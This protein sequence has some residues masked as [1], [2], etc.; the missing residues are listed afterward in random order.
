[1]TEP[2][3][4]EAFPDDG[5]AAAASGTIRPKRPS[6]NFGRYAAAI[7]AV[8]V[9]VAIAFLVRRLAGPESVDLAFLVFVIGVAIRYG[10]G[11]SFIASILS[12]LALN[13]FFVVPV[14]SFEVA[15]PTNLATLFFF[16]VVALVTS[17]LAAQ[18]RS[19][20][21]AARRR[22]VEAEALYG[23][24]RRLSELIGLDELLQSTLKQVRSM[25]SLDGVL[26]LRDAGDRIR[27]STPDEY[28]VRIDDID[29]AAVQASWSGDIDRRDALRVGRRFYFPCVP[30]MAGSA[31]SAFRAIG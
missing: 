6:S 19:Q 4:D 22:A 11:P 2:R 21:I 3:R 14:H 5:H 24:S 27:I 12:V 29:L 13:F 31:R 10:L 17:Q 23:F 18:A 15:D 9:A 8:A 28:S 7:A 25:L 20:T 30:V 26:L 16:T 1:M